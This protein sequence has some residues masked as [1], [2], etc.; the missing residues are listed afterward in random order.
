MI[1]IQVRRHCMHIIGVHV[2]RSALGWRAVK[3]CWAAKVTKSLC[4][5]QDLAD[6]TCFTT[7]DIKSTL[8]RLQIL[9]YSQ[10]L[11][12]E[13]RLGLSYASVA[14][15]GRGFVLRCN[16]SKLSWC[17]TKCKI[18][19]VL[20]LLTPTLN[21]SSTG[22]ASAVGK[23]S[24]STSQKYVGHLTSPRIAGSDKRHAWT[25]AKLDSAMLQAHRTPGPRALLHPT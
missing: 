23:G 20:T 15:L 16:G 14:W 9:Q 13:S 4:G 5:R 1:S 21:S 19:R 2:A 18:C 17:L 12:A 22:S 10:V 6:E 25:V 8:E 7:A 24:R 3:P 11:E